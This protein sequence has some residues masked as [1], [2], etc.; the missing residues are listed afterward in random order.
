MEKSREMMGR[1]GGG[2]STSS[3]GTW[4]LYEDGKTIKKI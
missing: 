1:K 2:E 3:I 4:G